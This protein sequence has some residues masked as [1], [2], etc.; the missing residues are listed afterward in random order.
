MIAENTGWVSYLIHDRDGA[1]VPLDGVLRTEG[2]EFVKT[3]PQSP[4]RN[5]YAERFVRETRVTLDSLILLGEP[6]FR[7]VLRQIEYHHNQHGPHQGLGNGIPLG[8]EYPDQPAPLAT[9]RCDV[10]LGGLLNHY[11]TKKMV[12]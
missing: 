6:H 2:A 4:M 1:F 7:H 11:Y 3:P 8:F 5:A 12:A 9:V 10:A